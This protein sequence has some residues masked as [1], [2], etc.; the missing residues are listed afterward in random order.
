MC[1][2]TQAVE[3]TQA[4]DLDD[5][6]TSSEQKEEVWGRL[7]SLNSHFPSIDLTG[8]SLTKRITPKSP[9]KNQL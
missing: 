7:I 1:D 8:K 2:A 6:S 4:V 5:D 9:R 3:F